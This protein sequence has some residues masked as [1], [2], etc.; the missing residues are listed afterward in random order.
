MAFKI[1][2][3]DFAD[4]LEPNLTSDNRSVKM[5][6]EDQQDIKFVTP[7]GDI[8]YHEQSISRKFIHSSGKLSISR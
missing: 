2:S 8:L 6:L 1:D 7:K 4:F 5:E 3:N